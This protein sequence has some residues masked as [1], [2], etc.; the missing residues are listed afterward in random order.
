M[1]PGYTISRF[2]GCRPDEGQSDL[3]RKQRR[4]RVADLDILF[5]ARPGELE[6]VWEGLQ[7]RGL[8]DSEYPIML[9]VNVSAPVEI[10]LCENR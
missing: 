9:G 3:F 6:P 8:P 1:Y 4:D 5:G 7:A 10:T 2:L